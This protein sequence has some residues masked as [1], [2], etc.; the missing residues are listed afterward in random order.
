MFLRS[1]FAAA[2]VALIAAPQAA[3]AWSSH[4]RTNLIIRNGPGTNYGPVTVI[5]AGKTV[6]VYHCAGWCEVYYEGCHGWVYGRYLARP[7]A[8]LASTLTVSPVQTR[9]GTMLKPVYVPPQQAYLASAPFRPP[10]EERADWYAGRA[11]YFDGRFLDRPDVFFV[12]GR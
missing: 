8:P 10:T 1:L 9:H 11:F 6:D 2:L 12:Y 4:T 7:Y 3:L 5:P